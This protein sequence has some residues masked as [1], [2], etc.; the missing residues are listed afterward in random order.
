M[1]RWPLWPPL[2]A[3]STSPSRLRRPHRPSSSCRQRTILCHRV[4]LAMSIAVAPRCPS[5]LS[6][7]CAAHRRSLP[8]RSRFITVAFVPSLADHHRRGAVVPDYSKWPQQQSLIVPRC[9]RY[10]RETMGLCPPLP[11]CPP[12]AFPGGARSTYMEAMRTTAEP[13]QPTG[14]RCP[15]SPSLSRSKRLSSRPPPPLPP[16][17]PSLRPCGGELRAPLDIIV[18]WRLP[19][20]IV[21]DP[22]HHRLSLSPIH[23]T[24]PLPSIAASSHC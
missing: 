5:L 20:R 1:P 18:R 21:R 12:R 14:R 4:V 9:R 7:H 10:R 19:Q 13:P 2:S 3:T 15:A 22:A 8:L 11:P 23:A 24:P 6:C 16:R 17:L